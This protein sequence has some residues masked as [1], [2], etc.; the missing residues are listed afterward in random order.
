MRRKF[1]IKLAFLNRQQIAKWLY[2]LGE[3][4]M[5]PSKFVE[6]Y[7]FKHEIGALFEINRIRR[8]L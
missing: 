2:E 7:E 4:L 6:E 8:F 5:G 1:P 3:F